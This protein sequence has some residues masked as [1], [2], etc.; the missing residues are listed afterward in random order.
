MDVITHL[1]RIYYF[2]KRTARAAV[3]AKDRATS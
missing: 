1:K 2:A 3:P